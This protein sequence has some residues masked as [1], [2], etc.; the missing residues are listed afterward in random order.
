MRQLSID[1][2]R[3]VAQE[4]DG[5]LLSKEYKNSYTP[6]VWQCNHGHRW[7]APAS[8]IRAGR[9]CPQCAISKT[10]SSLEEYQAIAEAR[11][12]R[13]LSETYVNAHTKLRW[14]CKNNHVWAAKPNNVKN[15]Q[16]CRLCGTADSAAK[17]K[18]PN[19]LKICATIAESRGGKC[20]SSV[21]VNNR[22]PMRWRCA[23][24]HEWN[25]P[26]GQ[27]QDGSWCP[28]CSEGI[29]ERVVR[30]HFEQLFGKPFPKSRP[31]WLKN[32][33]GNQMELDG[34]AEE[35]CLAFEHQGRQHYHHTKHF[36]RDKQDLQLRQLDDEQKRRLCR[37]HGVLLIEIPE[38]P[39]SLP[40]DKI[41]KY[42]EN[43]LSD[44][45][46]IDTVRQRLALF[47]TID[48]NYQKAYQVQPLRN[49]EE[50][51]KARGGS[52][53][54]KHYLGMFH[55]LEFQC[56]IGHVF[57]AQPVNIVHNS[58]WCP[59]CAKQK[60]RMQAVLQRKPIQALRA[61]AID[62][63]GVLLSSESG[64][65]HNKHHWRCAAGHTF[66]MTPANV[67]MGKWCPQ[68]GRARVARAVSQSQGAILDKVIKD[69]GG[70]ILSGS[71]K[72]ART[73]VHIRCAA[74]HEWNARPDAVIRGGWCPKCKGG[75]R[76]TI[77]DAK[78][79]AMRRGGACLSEIYINSHSP[80]LWRCH[81]GHTFSKPYTKVQQGQWCSKCKGT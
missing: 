38:V 23:A 15:G 5:T 41:K 52:V 74:G 11:G 7:E 72:T 18:L 56:G 16:W 46:T 57:T 60:Q 19:G 76:L 80:L 42:I 35:L 63:E 75:I 30:E 37:D 70:M 31:K 34:F 26:L 44:K 47:S 13:C 45:T 36:H 50:I 22:A 81:N 68:C 3:Q 59:I 27:I 73:K 12:G 8:S 62:R 14:Q 17:Q 78:A 64:G 43:H 1:T 48:V 51:A 53:L 4:R 10:K 67:L 69:R 58:Q 39:T 79:L 77:R 66:W 29:G 40:Y 49:I 2:L 71:Y 9:W 20:L 54:S 28:T 32:Q 21:Y 61:L 6:L 25:S 33:R 24:G 65:A 55:H